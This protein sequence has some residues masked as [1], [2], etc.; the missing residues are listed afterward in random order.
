MATFEKVRINLARTTAPP[1]VEISGTPEVFRDRR[2]FLVEIFTKRHDFLR[3][4]SDTRLSFLPA[5]AP[6]GYVAGFFGRESTSTRRKGPDEKYQEVEEENWPLSLLV[7]DLR[8]DSQIAWVERNHKVGSP[9]PLLEAFFSYLSRREGFSDWKAY[10][11][12]I[13]KE[14][15][16]WSVVREHRGEITSIS[17]TFIPPNALEAFDMVSDFIRSAKEESN[18]DTLTHTYKGEAGQMNPEGEIMEASAK[19]AMDGGGAAEV[20]SGHELLYSSR[21]N[22]SRTTEHVDDEEMPT[23]QKPTFVRRVIDRLFGELK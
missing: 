17:F 10:I 21:L 13:D 4:A 15:E 1:L 12:Y 6:E 7:L 22:R 8:S 2:E 16:Y 5:Q 9:R 11:E 18:P 20:R 19:I 23:P 3:G 14:E